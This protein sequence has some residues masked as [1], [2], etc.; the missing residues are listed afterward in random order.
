MVEKRAALLLKLLKTH[1]LRLEVQAGNAQR[2]LTAQIVW[3][4]STTEEDGITPCPVPSTR[5]KSTPKPT[6]EP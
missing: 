5:K 4:I 1:R 2:S 3:W 6:P